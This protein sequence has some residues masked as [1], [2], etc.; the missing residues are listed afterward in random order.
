VVA[1]AISIPRCQDWKGPRSRPRSGGDRRRDLAPSPTR[2]R[3]AGGREGPARSWSP[4]TV[5]RPRPRPAREGRVLYGFAGNHPE[6]GTAP[7]LQ[8]LT[9]TAM[10]Q[11]N[12]SAAAA[13]DRCRADGLRPGGHTDREELDGAR[14]AGAHRSLGRGHVWD[15]AQCRGAGGASGGLSPGRA[16]VVAAG[17]SRRDPGSRGGLVGSVPV[18]P[19]GACG[20]CLRRRRARLPAPGCDT[21]RSPRAG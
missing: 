20:C 9:W 4:V 11:I 8:A 17:V 5:A 3:T 1:P 6:M 13:A 12:R 7:I 2:P 19:G 18:P 15:W 16:Y 10:L 21:R 14:S